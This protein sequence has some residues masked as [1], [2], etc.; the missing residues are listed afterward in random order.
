MTS[1]LSGH[2]VFLDTSAEK[3]FRGSALGEARHQSG[4]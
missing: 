4:C 2:L 3:S 1:R